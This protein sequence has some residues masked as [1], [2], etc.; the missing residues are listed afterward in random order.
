MAE[1]AG[2]PL[3]LHAARRIVELDPGRKVA[4]CT[5]GSAVAGLLAPLGFEIIYNA[6][7]E[8]GLSTSIACGIASLGH[9][10]FAA[11]LVCLGDMPFVSLAHL[12]RLAARFDPVD[13]PV[14]ASVAAGVAMPPAIFAGAYFDRLRALQGDSGARALLASAA[15]V[16]AQPDELA[17][18]DT[19]KDLD[20]LSRRGLR[21]ES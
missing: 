9:E 18:V 1:L 4:V 5:K 3:V 14:V 19:V 6:A 17:D 7:P 10:A 13:A 20:T 8:N 11:V 12:H 21:I 2:E 16:A 15:R